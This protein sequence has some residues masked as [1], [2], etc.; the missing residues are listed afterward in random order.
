MNSV[1]WKNFF[2]KIVAKKIQ[3]VSL[4]RI[5]LNELKKVTVAANLLAN[6]LKVARCK[7]KYFLPVELWAFNKLEK[8]K[9]VQNVQQ[10]S[11]DRRTALAM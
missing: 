11:C 3:F 10:D 1:L 7:I 5:H 9:R 8:F 2:H 6:W 4:N